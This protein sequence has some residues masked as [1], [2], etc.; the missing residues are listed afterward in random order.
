MP[1]QKKKERERISQRKTKKKVSLNLKAI[2]ERI[3]SLSR[4]LKREHVRIP[5]IR[6]TMILIIGL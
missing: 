2:E 1:P 6:I 3:A 4:I 5:E